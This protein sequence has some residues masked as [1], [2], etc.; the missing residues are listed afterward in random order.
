[1]EAKKARDEGYARG[2]YGL[3]KDI[4]IVVLDTRKGGDNIEE[5]LERLTIDHRL[6]EGGEVPSA[7]LHPF[8]IFVANCAGEIQGDDA[9]RLEWFVRTGGY[10]FASCWALTETIGKTFP[11]IA[12]QHPTGGQVLDVVD[13]E[14]LPRSGRFLGGVFRKGTRTRYVLEGSHLIRVH[15]PERFEVLIDSPECAARWGEGNL[16][17]WFTVG[18]GLVFDSA[19]HFD[20][21][22]MKRDVPRKAAQRKAQA[23]DRLGYS[24]EEVRKLEKK[25]IFKSAGRS[26]KELEDLSMFRLI[27]NFV[28]QKRLSEL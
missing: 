23:M 27:T 14:A 18:H 2:G 6:C 24:H 17:G 4:D 21:Q 20:L 15:D 22:G 8:A 19:N 26:T 11:G 13:A 12:S 9:N 1:M 25:G 7:K 28:R 3:Y 5:L 16:A 10:M